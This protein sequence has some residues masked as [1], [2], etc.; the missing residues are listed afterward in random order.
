MRDRHRASAAKGGQLSGAAGGAHVHGLAIAVAVVM[1]LAEPSIRLRL[2]VPVAS[3]RARSLAW[4][5]RTWKR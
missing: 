4:W 2:P 3:G 1:G 5:L